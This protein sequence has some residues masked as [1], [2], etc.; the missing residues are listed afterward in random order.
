MVNIVEEISKK[1][2]PIMFTVNKG[3]NKRYNPL[4]TQN[5]NEELAT[6]LP[7][8]AKKNLELSFKWHTTS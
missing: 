2:L 4:I 5:L 1:F 3:S 7:E 6:S 8:I